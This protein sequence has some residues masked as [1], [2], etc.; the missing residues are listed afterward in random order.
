MST[1]YTKERVN[2]AYKMM[3]RTMTDTDSGF[4]CAPNFDVNGCMLFNNAELLETCRI[5][6]R[7]FKNGKLTMNPENS[8]EKTIGDK[9][10]YYFVLQATDEDDES[11]DPILLF[12]FGVLVS[13]K[14]MFFKDKANRDNIQDWLIKK[15]TN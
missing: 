1:C 4:C 8:G 9:T 5:L 11:I 7:N 13:G 15:L 3:E 12:V 10:W 2:S 14:A 6:R